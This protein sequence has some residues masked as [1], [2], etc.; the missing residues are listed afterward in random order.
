MNWLKNKSVVSTIATLTILSIGLLLTA[1]VAFCQAPNVQ[2]PPPSPNITT[3][4]G[5]FTILKEIIRWIY[6]LFFVIAIAF[7]LVAAFTYVTAGGDTEKV[8]KAKNYLIYAIIGI[9]V[10]LL[11]FGLSTIISSFLQNPTA[12]S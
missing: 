2:A 7:I 4:S 9:V 1:S 11:S 10:A 8:G 12:T 3:V 5:L 6:T